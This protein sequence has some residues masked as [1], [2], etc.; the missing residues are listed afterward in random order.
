MKTV[1]K[2][3]RKKIA[4]GRVIR[5]NQKIA[6][7]KANVE[8]LSEY[9]EAIKPGNF[10]LAITSAQYTID[11]LETEISRLEYK[12]SGILNKYFNHPQE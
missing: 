6:V 2:D 11:R 12:R 1:F 7:L 5:I 10:M 4:Y 8:E 9:L 3:L